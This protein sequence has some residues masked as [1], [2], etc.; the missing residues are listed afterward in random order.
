MTTY[1]K[2]WIDSQL[3]VFPQADKAVLE[4][5][6]KILF[7]NGPSKTWDIHH[8]FA[9]GYCYYFANMLKT[10][11]GRGMI[12]YAY[13]QDHIVWLDGTSSSKDIAYDIYGVSTDWDCLIPIEKLG[14]EILD[15]M[16]VPGKQSDMSDA[17]IIKLEKTLIDNEEYLK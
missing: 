3:K 1:E 6:A 16:H 13:N 4:F 5:I 10:A 12:C 17:E 14:N 11:F 8:L 2:D 7:H 9:A 15:F